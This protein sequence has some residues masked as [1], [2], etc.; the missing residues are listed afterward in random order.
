[1]ALLVPLSGDS[2][3]IGQSIVQ[4]VRLGINK[5]NN[6]RLLVI[7]KDTKSDQTTTVKVVNELYSEGI[8]IFIGP[9]FNKNLK[10]LSKFQDATFLS[11]TNKIIIIPV[12]LLVL[13]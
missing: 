1:M 6:N 3:H 2:S 13:E 8:K 10:E 12:M 4:S 9:V 7:P 11:F 5:I